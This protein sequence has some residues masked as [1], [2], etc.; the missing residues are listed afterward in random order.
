MLARLRARGVTFQTKVLGSRAGVFAVE[1]IDVPRA[2]RDDLFA[3][4]V[5]LVDT[6]DA[7]SRHG[8]SK[9]LLIIFV[10]VAN[11]DEHSDH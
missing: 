2:L 6:I 7:N 8:A 3:W 5:D 10:Q 1:A 9:S 11:A 4:N